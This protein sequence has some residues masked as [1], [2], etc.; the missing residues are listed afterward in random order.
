LRKTYSVITMIC[1]CVWCI[2]ACNC[3][4]D[5]ELLLLLLLCKY[6]NYPSSEGPTD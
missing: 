5:S 1:I 4:W 6:I 3:R 2:S